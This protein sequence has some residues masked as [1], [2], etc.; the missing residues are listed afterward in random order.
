MKGMIA[1]AITLFDQKGADMDQA[2]LVT[3]LAESLFVPA[4]LL[5]SDIVFEEISDLR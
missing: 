3:Y 2:C 1:K 5:Q 4:V